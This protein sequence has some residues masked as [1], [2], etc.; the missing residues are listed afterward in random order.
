M[1]VSLLKLKDGESERSASVA[2]FHA[3]VYSNFVSD[4]VSKTS[5]TDSGPSGTDL[6]VL[7]TNIHLY[8]FYTR[9][10]NYLIY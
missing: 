2:H 6:N 7:T 10:R 9:S 3:P 8:V 4:I 5:D 1:V